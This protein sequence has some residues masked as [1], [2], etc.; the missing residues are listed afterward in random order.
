MCGAA[1][2]PVPI[3]SRKGS[4][5]FLN[6]YTMCFWGGGEPER[7]AFSGSFGGGGST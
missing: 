2:N 3:L 1:L 4:V 5:V 6:R 7:N